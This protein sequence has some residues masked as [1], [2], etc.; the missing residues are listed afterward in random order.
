MQDEIT[1]ASGLVNHVVMLWMNDDVATDAYLET[2][3]EDMQELL[4]IEHVLS[5]ETGRPIPS[6]RD[7][8]NNS[9]HIGARIVVK[10]AEVMNDYLLHPIHIDVGQRH[11]PNIR[12]QLVYDF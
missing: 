9:F 5:V 12:K 3:M 2:V 11:L 4:E 8:V 10:S 1:G 6:E 7:V